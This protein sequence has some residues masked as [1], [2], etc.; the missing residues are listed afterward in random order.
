VRAG[1]DPDSECGEAIVRLHR[2]WLSYTL[3]H[4]SRETHLGI[5]SLYTQ[6]ERFTAYYDREVPG[7]AA[8]LR[9]AVTAALS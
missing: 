9:A 3:P 4:Y 7:C 8:F 1:K 2:Q 5:A 6:D